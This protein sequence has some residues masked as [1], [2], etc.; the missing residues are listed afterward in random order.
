[1]KLL[2]GLGN[3]GAKYAKNRHNIGFMAVDRIA[4]A[5]DFGPWRDK[6]QGLVSEGRFG[7]TKTL[8]LKPTTFMNNSGQSAAAA[9]RFYKLAPENVAVLYDELDL[10]PGKCRVKQ[11]GGTAGHNGIRSLHGHIGPDYLRVRLGIG[12]PGDKS[13]VSNYVLGDFAKADKAWLDDL[14]TGIADGAPALVTGGTASFVSA[15]ALRTAPPRSSPACAAPRPVPG[16]K[17]VAAEPETRS[18]LQR[19]IDKFS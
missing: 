18:R 13:L 3:P 8:L 11:G 12:H 16:P 9:L 5:H 15:V 14:L 6:F 4:E 2:I 1:M 17:M 7:S 19:L 10:A